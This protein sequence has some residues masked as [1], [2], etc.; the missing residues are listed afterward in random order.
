ML[1]RL[2]GMSIIAAAIAAAACGSSSD[3]TTS[4]PVSK[5]VN[6]SATMTPAGEP[7]VTGSPTG[8]G[9]FTATLDTSTGVFTW[10]ATFSGLSSP[11]NNGH[12]HGPFLPGTSGSAK[13]ILDFHSSAIPGETFDGFGGTSGSAT[14][15]IV[16]NAN[17]TGLVGI[18]GDSLKSLLLSGNTYVNIH[19]QQN[20]GGE[21]RAQIVKQ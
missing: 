12:I 15:S 7:S 4:P 10:K 2:A 6:F 5:I 1:H 9:T 11:V 14:G 16:L 3:N 20:P 18:T 19:T 21:I 8:S 13:V 17:T